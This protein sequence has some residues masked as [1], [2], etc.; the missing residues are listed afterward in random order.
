MIGKPGAVKQE[1]LIQGSEQV[2]ELLPEQEGPE[3]PDICGLDVQQ[4]VLP[5]EKPEENCCIPRDV[6]NCLRV[7]LG[8]PEADDPTTIDLD[9]KRLDCSETRILIG[10]GVIGHRINLRPPSRA[11]FANNAG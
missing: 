10:F 3:A 11:L 4:R 2:D 5:V 6:D 8:I 1:V 7:L 9:G